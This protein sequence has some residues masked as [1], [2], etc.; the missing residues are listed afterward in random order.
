M[1]S[2][3]NTLDL[4]LADNSWKEPNSI[5]FS[6]I[7]RAKIKGHLEGF[8]EGLIEQHAAAR[9]ARRQAQLVKEGALKPFHE[10]MLPSS[11]R[12]I[13]AFERS[14]STGLGNTFEAVAHLIAEETH[15]DAE[16]GFKMI[17]DI[18]STA[19]A[20]IDELVARNNASG[21]PMPFP[22]QIAAVVNAPPSERVT[23]R[24]I[25]DLYFKKADGSEWFFE[26]KSPKPNKGQCL[27]VTARL[28]TTHAIRAKSKTPVHTYFAM[29]YNPFGSREDYK[30]SF[31]NRHLDM[32]VQVLI[33][34]EFWTV[35]GEDPSTYDAVL[36]IYGEV[37]EQSSNRLIDRLAFG[38]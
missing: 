9:P 35:V 14:F 27:E 38:F 20:R 30:W 13:N 24:A 33:Q 31:A 28:L 36:K 5:V 4:T 19:A 6:D 22:E 37:G 29:A 26:M 3:G 7:V 10:A 23:R 15:V 32:Q 25:A 34:E 11:I 16:R 2:S 17:V 1:F 21:I 12:R 8:I 18:P